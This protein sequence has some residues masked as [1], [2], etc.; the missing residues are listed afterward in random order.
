MGEMRLVRDFSGIPSNLE[1]LKYG[2]EEG[3]IGS[4]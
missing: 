4:V 1:S 3:W 2:A